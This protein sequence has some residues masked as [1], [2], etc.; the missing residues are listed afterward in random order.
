MSFAEDQHPV[1]DLGPGCE[2]GPFGMGARARASGRD[3]HGLD[4]RA[5]QDCIER[6]AELPGPIADQELEVSVRPPRHQVAPIAYTAGSNTRRNSICG[7]HVSG[8]GS[9][10]R[11]QHLQSASVTR[12]GVPYSWFQPRTAR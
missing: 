10:T 5:G 9:V 12:P 11:E 8:M 4:A 7:R 6:C 1:G 3:L 2:H